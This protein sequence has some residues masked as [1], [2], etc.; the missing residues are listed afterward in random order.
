MMIKLNTNRK[1][2]VVFSIILLF[3]GLFIPTSLLAD[4]KPSSLFCDHMVLQRSVA[5]PVWGM[6]T[7]GNK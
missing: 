1:F 6:A 4:V 5:I 3:G 2:K 7:K